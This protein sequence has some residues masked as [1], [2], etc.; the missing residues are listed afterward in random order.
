M[1]ADVSIMHMLST[2]QEWAKDK[3]AQSLWTQEDKDNVYEWC[4]EAR[5]RLPNMD[6]KTSG[7]GMVYKLVQAPCTRLG[8]LISGSRACGAASRFLRTP[9]RQSSRR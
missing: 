8:H 4:R 5:G 3:T 9:I 2:C 6:K 1:Y 7:G